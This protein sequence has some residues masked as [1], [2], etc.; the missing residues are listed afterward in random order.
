MTW[1]SD[2]EAALA[3]LAAQFRREDSTSRAVDAAAADLVHEE[4]TATISRRDGL[5][6]A[7]IACA[8]LAAIAAILWLGG[9][10]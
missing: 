3:E 1:T 10:W 8:V 4:I 6:K 9:V 5:G 7:V 2:D